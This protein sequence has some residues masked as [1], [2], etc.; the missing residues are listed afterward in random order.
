MVAVSAVPTPARTAGAK[1]PKGARGP[2]TGK[3]GPLTYV[4]A[5][6]FVGVCLAPIAYI[7]V[8]GFRTN[9]QITADPSGLPAPWQLSNYV[10]VL[11]SSLF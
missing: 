4:V 5:Y 2:A 9:A 8:G 1:A 6:L 7:V 11:S 3:G 10:E